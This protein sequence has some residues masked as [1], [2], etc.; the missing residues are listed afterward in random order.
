VCLGTI[1][2]LQYIEDNAGAQT[3]NDFKKI[4]IIIISSKLQRAEIKSFQ[5]NTD[6]G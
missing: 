4:I 2:E 6:E 1:L 5:P 3:G